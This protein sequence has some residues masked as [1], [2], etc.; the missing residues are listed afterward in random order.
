MKTHDYK[1]YHEEYAKLGFTGTYFLAFRDIHELTKGLSGKALDY[2]CG[3]GRSTLFVKNLGFETVGVDINADMLN[4]AKQ[5]DSSGEYKLIESGRIP[6][7]ADM[8]DF[9]FSSFVFLEVSSLEEIENIM[10]ESK[11]VLKPDGRFI[12][13]TNS[14][15]D[16]TGE[17]IS[18][19]Y[20][21]PENK[22]ELKSGD[23]LKLLIKN[24]NIVLYDYYWS[25]ADYKSAISR[26]KLD[27][28]KIHRPLGR[29]NDGI[30]WKDESKKENFAI[31][32]LKKWN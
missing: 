26:A 5:A 1:N 4:D 8:F 29:T 7:A 16:C 12:F 2:G 6:Y 10:K 31:Y 21:F 15:T 27:L 9:V 28:E 18:F 14:I 30:E 23:T 19:S 32:I 3:A 22:K 11:R 25:E 24:G 20:D 17:W 13:I